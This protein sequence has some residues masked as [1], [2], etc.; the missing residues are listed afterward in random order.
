M[1]EKRT[2]T[3]QE[4]SAYLGTNSKEATDRKLNN[5]KIS[6]TSEGRGKSRIYTITEI[7]DRFKGNGKRHIR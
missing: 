3:F 6:Y 1:L 2:Y 4:L 7:P 5:Y